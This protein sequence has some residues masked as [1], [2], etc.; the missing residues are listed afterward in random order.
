MISCDI[1][2]MI[3]GGE[4]GLRGGGGSWKI[5]TFWQIPHK[6]VKIFH[7]YFL[8]IFSKL[9]ALQR[10]NN[11]KIHEIREIIQQ[12][13]HLLIHDVMRAPYNNEQPP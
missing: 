3:E 10:V 6:P 8:P 12:Q 13:H 7:T 9:E 11:I 5:L 1:I 2:G 4:V